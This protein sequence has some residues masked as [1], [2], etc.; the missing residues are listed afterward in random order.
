MLSREGESLFDFAKR[1]KEIYPNSEDYHH[2]FSEF[3]IIF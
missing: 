1:A 3:K 2:Q